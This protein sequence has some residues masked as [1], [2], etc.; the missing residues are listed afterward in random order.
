[1]QFETIIEYHVPRINCKEDGIK[2]MDVPWTGKRS[3]FTL[4]FERFAIGVIL[5]SATQKSAMDLLR[6]SWDEVHYIQ[7][8]SVQR[9]LKKKKK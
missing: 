5:H 8:K 4:L 1:M 9:G 7:E 2:T 3:Q 6:L